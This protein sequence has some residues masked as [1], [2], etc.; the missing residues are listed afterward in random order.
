MV[1]DS[2]KLK[3]S[4]ALVGNGH[5]SYDW[6]TGLEVREFDKVLEF[7]EELSPSA[8]YLLI[9]EIGPIGGGTEVQIDSALEFFLHH[10][11]QRQKV[12]FVQALLH[13]FLQMHGDELYGT[14]VPDVR[15]ILVDQLETQ[16]RTDWSII[17]CQM[18]QLM[19][20]LKFL[21]HLQ[22]E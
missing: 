2:V 15:R 4:A 18:Q 1:E 12:D 5:L 16:M 13:V 7:F 19:C 14:G 21:T 20:S 10:T 3:K 9:Q 11:K 6:Q 8:I 17:E 22:M